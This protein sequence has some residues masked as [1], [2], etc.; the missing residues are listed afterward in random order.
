MKKILAIVL[1]AASVM[2]FS[3]CST[4][5]GGVAD[6]TAPSTAETVTETV[7]ETPVPPVETPPITYEVSYIGAEGKVVLPF[8]E[9]MFY[10]DIVIYSNGEYSELTGDGYLAFYSVENYLP[11]C[12]DK[13]PNVALDEASE[14]VITAREGVSFEEVR[15][16]DVYC[17][18]GAGYE[19]IAESVTLAEIV[20]KGEKEWKNQTLYLYFDVGFYDDWAAYN[21]SVRNGYF[22]K[23]V[24]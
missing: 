3:A 7:T 13:I 15:A 4:I 2:G 18:D 10:T 23:T 14:I 8:E 12:A 16:V 1:A 21:K 9:K 5:P 11:I 24:F 17:A 20:K 19:R 22:V 6:I